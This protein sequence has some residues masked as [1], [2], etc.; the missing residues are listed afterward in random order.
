MTDGPDGRRSAVDS[1]RYILRRWWHKFTFQRKW[2]FEYK[3]YGW[4]LYYMHSS[5]VSFAKEPDATGR[6]Q[7]CPDKQG[8]GFYD[9]REKP[10]VEVRG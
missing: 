2:R 9:E 7:Y 8:D 1:L 10:L 5:C 6:I 4:S 3:T